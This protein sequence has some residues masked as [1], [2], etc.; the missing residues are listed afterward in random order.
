M[1]ADAQ[2][3]SVR[4]DQICRHRS[5]RAKAAVGGM[6]LIAVLGIGMPSFPAPAEAGVPMLAGKPRIETIRA[7]VP[8]QGRDAGRLRV[9]VRVAHASG[10]A[11]AVARE[12]PETVHSGRVTARVGGIRR[13]STKRL[14]VTRQRVPGGYH[15]RFSR[16]GT[17]AIA[18]GGLRRVTVSVRTTQAVDV[19][20][21]GRSE[22]RALASTARSVPL[23]S[24]AVAIVPEDG[25][26]VHAGTA[27]DRVRV[28]QGHVDSY[29]LPSAASACGLTSVGDDSTRISAP[30]DP[31]TGQFSF[32]D[33]LA[34]V[35]TKMSGTF[36]P[37]G[38]PPTWYATIDATFKFGDCTFSLSGDQRSYVLCPSSW[39]SCQFQSARFT[40]SSRR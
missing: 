38:S 14:A 16:A 13:V 8:R 21:D 25:W 40:S 5:L 17:R 39:Q 4:V 30:V 33:N 31:Q 32:D 15:F 35:D 22:D 23:A 19:D 1:F 34:I 27:A 7:F 28:E 6:S 18:T 20:S 2:T 3:P 29:N 10:T 11:R 36:R 24:P 26:Y 37:G 9:W 12:R